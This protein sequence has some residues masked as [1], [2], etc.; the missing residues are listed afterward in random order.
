MGARQ[1]QEVK[2]G[3]SAAAERSPLAGC[4]LKDGGGVASLWY[5][6]DMFIG[7]RLRRRPAPTLPR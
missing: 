5:E 1:D 7:T 6:G 4:S 3:A 2:R